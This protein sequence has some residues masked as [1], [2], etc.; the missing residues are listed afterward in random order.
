MPSLSLGALWQRQID[1]A[2]YAPEAFAPTLDRVKRLLDVQGIGSRRL[3][4]PPRETRRRCE[5]FVISTGKPCRRPAI[6]GS[7][8]C[9]VHERFV[10]RRE[11]GRG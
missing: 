10:A 9:V 3:R 8:F 11:N 4:R 2:G 5:G 7:D 6:E 1:M